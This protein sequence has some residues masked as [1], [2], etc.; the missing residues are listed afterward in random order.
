MVLLVFNAGGWAVIALR[1]VALP[2]NLEII[3]IHRLVSQPPVDVCSIYS[4]HQ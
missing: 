4:L 1:I 3:A 2:A